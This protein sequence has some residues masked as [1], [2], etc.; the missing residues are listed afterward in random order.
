VRNAPRLG[1]IVP[2]LNPGNEINVSFEIAANKYV[3]FKLGHNQLNHNSH[4]MMKLSV[5][6]FLLFASF[7]AAAATVYF[8]K[9]DIESNN[10]SPYNSSL[11]ISFT[12]FPVVMQTSDGSQT[13]STNDTFEYDFTGSTVAIVKADGTQQFINMTFLNFTGTLPPLIMPTNNC[14]V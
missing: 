12:M 5:A 10:S 11:G 3:G 13:F 1:K 2:V 6:V 14:C 8:P 4:S 7:H 9:F